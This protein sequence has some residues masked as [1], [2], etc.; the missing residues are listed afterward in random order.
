MYGI[1]YVIRNFVFEI[2]F[3]NIV[4]SEELNQYQIIKKEG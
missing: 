2:L 1:I 3:E 4:T